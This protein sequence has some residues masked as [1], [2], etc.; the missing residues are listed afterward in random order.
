MTHDEILVLIKKAK[1]KTSAF[2][3][4]CGMFVLAL[5]DVIG[6]GDIVLCT[7]SSDPDYVE[8]DDAFDNLLNGEPDIWHVA[9]L[10]NGHMYDGL[11][12]VTIDSLT[13]FC[14]REYRDDPYIQAWTLENKAD[15][16]QMYKII[17]WNT[18]WS[19]D[20]DYFIKKLIK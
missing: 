2:G 12:E 8:G 19:Y 13:D 11:G 15:E 6:G 1:V 17:R 7:N 14:I 16:D 20:K 10:M 18:D 3:G 9:L 4:N 5:R